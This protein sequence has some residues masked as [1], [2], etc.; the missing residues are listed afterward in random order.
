VEGSATVEVFKRDDTTFD[1]VIEPEMA[2]TALRERI[3]GQPE[4]VAIIEE[5]VGNLGVRLTNG[6]SLEDVLG[7]TTHITGRY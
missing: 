6:K 1:L 3:K 2:G 7:P 5:V 4:E